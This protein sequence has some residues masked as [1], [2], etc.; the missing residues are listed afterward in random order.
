MESE[1][2][3]LAIDDSSIADDMAVTPTDSDISVSE[4]TVIVS[5]GDT[6]TSCEDNAT[7][8]IYDDS[9]LIAVVSKIADNTTQLSKTVDDMQATQLYGL[10]SLFT[11]GGVILAVCLAKWIYHK[12]IF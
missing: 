8:P 9:S 4:T 2:D 6:D 7:T 1:V 3:Y 10:M 12:F 5:S 11:V